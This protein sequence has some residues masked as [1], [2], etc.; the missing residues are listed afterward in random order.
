V[1]GGGID[2]REEN[3]DHPLSSSDRT[4]VFGKSRRP[5]EPHGGHEPEDILISTGHERDVQDADIQ[6]RLRSGPPPLTLEARLATVAA[7]PRLETA[8]FAFRNRGDLTFEDHSADWGFDLTEVSQGMALGDFD[9]DGDLDVA[10]NNLNGG[11][12]LCRTETGVSRP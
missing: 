4:V 5:K 8:N 1:N 12:V 9:N 6:A 2:W 7:F 11:A 10:L 3:R